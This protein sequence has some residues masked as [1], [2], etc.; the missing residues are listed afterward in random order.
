GERLSRRQLIK[1]LTVLRSRAGLS[2]Q[3]LAQKLGRTQSKVSKLEGSDDADVRLGDVVDY[4]VA[5]GHEVRVFLVPKGQT[6]VEEAKMHAFVIKRLLNRLAE[7]AGDDEAT[8]D[9]VSGF[10]SEA[11]YDLGKVVGSAARLPP[12]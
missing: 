10:L 5:V 8:P 3:E 2:Q 12:L 1:V 4:A 6:I 7:L 11:F 9:G